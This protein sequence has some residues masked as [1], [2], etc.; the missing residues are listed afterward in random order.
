MCA[1]VCVCVCACLCACVPVCVLLYVCVCVCMCARVCACV[2]GPPPVSPA[3]DCPPNI[4]PVRMQVL[5]DCS[6]FR[7]TPSG[8]SLSGNFGQLRVINSCC[9]QW[10]SILASV[11]AND[12]SALPGVEQTHYVGPYAEGN[13]CRKGK[14][15]R[16]L[17]CSHDLVA[18]NTWEVQRLGAATCFY[19][20]RFE[21]RQVDY[22]LASGDLT[23]GS[24][25][26]Q[27]METLA[28]R[29][30]HRP[31]IFREFRARHEL[32]AEKR[33]EIT[34]TRK[35][36]KCTIHSPHFVDH[37]AAAVV[38]AT[39]CREEVFDAQFTVYTDGHY[40][41]RRRVSRRNVWMGIRCI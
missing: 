37:V 14:L 7:P 40:S 38:P 34:F 32:R 8:L 3:G 41:R 19:D 36:I 31:I 25:T 27:T 29:S 20:G 2:L 11:D 33:S 1:C 10:F 16:Q 39:R 17:L 28:S 4:I 12:C 18:T 24:Y 21:A 22:F 30:D 13:A 23:L 5:V 15:F 26:C 6:R 35:P 9:T